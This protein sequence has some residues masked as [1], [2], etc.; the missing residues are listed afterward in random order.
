MPLFLYYRPS[1][2]RSLKHLG[3]QQKQVV[4]KILECLSAYYN[5]NCNIGTVKEIDSGFFYKQLQ[6]PYYEAGIESNIRVV[7]IREADK[8]IAVLAGNHDQIRQFL[9]NI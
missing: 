8:C 6:K 4:A 2:S 3:T 5:S 1:F 7:L 9:N